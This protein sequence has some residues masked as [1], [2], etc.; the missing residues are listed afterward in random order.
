MQLAAQAGAEVTAVCSA[1]NAG[2]VRSLGAHRTI[3]YRS[4]DFT[5]PRDAYDI[6]FDTV[7]KT[8]FTRCQGCLR[9]SGRYLVTVMSAGSI[10][11]TLCTLCTTTLG[12]L[13][14][15]FG[16]GKKA[17]FA[18]SV[19]KL[20][21]LREIKTQV[22]QGRHKPVIDRVYPLAEIGEAHAYVDTGRKRG[23]VVIAVGHD[24]RAR[25]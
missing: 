18:M 25:A 19:D 17:I 23:N 10:A 13:L 24:D 16:G 1:R 5:R 8:T 20:G 14:P 9:D 22:E 6:V 4:E 7:G 21:E 11:A 2:L 12:T 15:C 3:D